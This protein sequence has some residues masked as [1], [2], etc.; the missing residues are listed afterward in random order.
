M[1]AH[2]ALDRPA[3]PLRAPVTATETKTSKTTSTPEPTKLVDA[4]FHDILTQHAA[5]PA[6]HD[7]AEDVDERLNRM[8]HTLESLITDARSVLS[9][10]EPTDPELDAD[11]LAL[12]RLRQA[13]AR[14]L[15]E[16]RAERTFDDEAY[17]V[18][19]FHSQ[20]APL[21]RAR[22]ISSMSGS[23]I[24][25]RRSVYGPSAFGGGASA[26]PSTRSPSLRAMSML[27]HT[28][29]TPP[30][31][32]VLPVR[33][34]TI[35]GPP[36]VPPRYAAVSRPSSRPASVVAY[37]PVEDPED[38]VDDDYPGVAAAVEPRLP[39]YPMSRNSSEYGL[40]VVSE[41]SLTPSDSP[42]AGYFGARRP[43]FR[44]AAGLWRW[45]AE[46]SDDIVELMVLDAP[47]PG[48]ADRSTKKRESTATASTKRRKSTATNTSSRKRAG[49]SRRSQAPA[50]AA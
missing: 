50:P 9:T 41:Y 43:G 33:A 20:P 10:P 18:S 22:P 17:T 34:S 31:Q 13:R 19:S 29:L 12:R 38:V 30:P 14:M 26:P 23:A 47:E 7:D 27:A 48:K 5:P 46:L 39:A 24:T 37:M 45:V 4:F 21:A 25:A 35:M 42:S 28:P 3:T 15:A 2:D 32:R 1:D 11:L 8:S 16:D 6:L 40:D 49:G 44:P 36:A